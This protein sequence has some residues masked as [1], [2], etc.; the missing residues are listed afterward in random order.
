MS[1]PVRATLRQDCDESHP[2]GVDRLLIRPTRGDRAG[3]GSKSGQVPLKAPHR[4]D[5][6]SGHP[7][8]TVTSLGLRIA[9]P[10]E[11][12]LTIRPGP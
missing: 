10:V 3:A 6:I 2:T 8:A 1:V 11:E 5:Q 4:A 9:E 12:R 7:L